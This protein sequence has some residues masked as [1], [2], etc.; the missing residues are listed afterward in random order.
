VQDDW[1]QDL[2]SQMVRGIVDTPQMVTVEA[3][4]ESYGTLY[5]VGVAEKEVGQIIG[6]SGRTARALRTLL[7]AIAMKEKR[8]IVLDIVS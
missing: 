4:S 2:I 5:R 8:R 3:V 7:A 1:V 6:K